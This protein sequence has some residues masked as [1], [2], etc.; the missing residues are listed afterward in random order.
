[1]H[2]ALGAALLDV[3]RFEEALASF[4][5]RAALEPGSAAA[6]SAVL[7]CRLH[8]PRVSEEEQFE[9]HVRLAEMNCSGVVAW[10]SSGVKGNVAYP[11]TPPPDHH[12]TSPLRVGYVSPDFREHTVAR[13]FEPVLANHDPAAV[14]SVCYS[15]VARPDAVTAR[16]RA[17]AGEWRETPGMSDEQLAE[18]IRA[19]RIDILVDL[20][21]HRG[22][23]R[24]RVFARKPAPVQA[25]YLG[26]PH[27]TGVGA[28]DYR[29]TDAV[30][31]PPGYDGAVPRRAAREAGGVRV[32]LSAGRGRAAGG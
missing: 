5:R 4:A 24:L 32:V 27:S 23:G 29:I 2:G 31:D 19:D 26:Y 10:L 6:E 28:L 1:V 7:F 22:G 3:G 21:G 30:S 8:D 25:T 17:C 18:K 15:D 14:T 9:G 11:T 13:F 20:T 12:P 16:L